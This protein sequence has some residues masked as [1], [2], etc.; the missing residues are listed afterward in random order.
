[1]T[2]PAGQSGSLCRAIEAQ[3]GRALCFPVLA[4]GPVADQSVFGAV[5]ERLDAFDLAFFVS[6]N[7]V[8]FAL[9]G[10][11]ALRDWPPRLRV[12]TVGKGSER[13]LAARGFDDVIA[14]LAGF[15]SEAVLDL[16]AFS[17]ET[18]RGRKVLVLRGDGGRD[19]LGETL[20]ERGATV[21]YLAC[22]RRFCPDIDSA[23]L[24]DPVRRGEIDALLLTSTEGARNLAAMVGAEGM[25]LLSGL[26][27]FASH[28][29]IAA[30]CRELG[31]GPVIETD[32][33]DEGLLRAL[34]QHFG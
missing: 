22:Y 3:G 12:A 32:A 34:V 24:L 31:L 28:P 13:A 15:D 30:Q 25:D 18:V 19:L 2:R 1:M 17:A 6:P 29:R 14:P 23:L 8:N 7:A 4:V 20:I 5:A 10:L 26:P 27:V 9:D 11:L 16:P 33:G 21:E